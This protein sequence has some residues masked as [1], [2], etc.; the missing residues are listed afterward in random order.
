MKIKDEN[1]NVPKTINLILSK[2][3][4]FH[5]IIFE[6]IKY[7]RLLNLDNSSNNFFKRLP[8]WVFVKDHMGVS[9]V[10]VRLS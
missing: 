10:V 4:R 3:T 7:L 9:L 5:P 2:M 8:P 1:G 6:V